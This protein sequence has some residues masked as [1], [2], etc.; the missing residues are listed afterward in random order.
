M[1]EFNQFFSQAYLWLS[2]LGGL[3]CVTLFIYIRF[4]H[5]VPS[6]DH[7]LL[8]WIIGLI[9]FYFLTGMIN[10][11]NAP[12]PINILFTL[13]IPM[14]FLLMPLV[15]LYCKRNVTETSNND[16]SWKHFYPAVTIATLVILTL[17]YHWLIPI[18]LSTHLFSNVWIDQKFNII[19]F[20]FPGLLSLQAA[21]YFILIFNLLNIF[22]FENRSFKNPELSQIKF[23]WL[24]ILT[25]ALIMN[26]LVRSLLIML[27][28]YT[29]ESISVFNLLLSRIILLISLYILA[30]Y[31]LKQITDLTYLKNQKR[32]SPHP[33]RPSATA[34]ELLLTEEELDFIHQ[35]MNENK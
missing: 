16:L 18:N 26:W 19:F 21:F 1:N 6:K 25:F 24:L 14:Y 33:I 3:H 23:K 28:F 12:L 10:K 5:R 32:S 29:G 11:H 15:Y 30:F 4:V 7:N 31:G 22:P 20:V 13:L 35:V 8:A 2:L 27:P 9:A 17:S 34:K